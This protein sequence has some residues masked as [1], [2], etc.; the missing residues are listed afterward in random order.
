MRQGAA[1]LDGGTAC[2]TTTVKTE[3]VVVHAA[4]PS[5]PNNG[6]AWR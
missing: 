6:G 5:N 2:M 4:T 1:G 3:R